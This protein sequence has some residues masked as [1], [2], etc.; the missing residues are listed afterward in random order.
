MLD[1]KIGVKSEILL[2]GRFDASQVDK[3]RTV[4]DPINESKTVD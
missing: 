1:I 2:S 4:F 3:A